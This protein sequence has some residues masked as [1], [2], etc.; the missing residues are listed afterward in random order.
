MRQAGRRAVIQI[1]K[2]LNKG[3]RP[4]LSLSGL[5]IQNFLRGPQE[6]RHFSPPPTFSISGGRRRR[7]FLK[8]KAKNVTVS[9]SVIFTR[10]RYG[11]V[12]PS[13]KRNEWRFFPFRLGKVFVFIT[14]QPA[15]T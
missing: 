11:L 15:M 14:F 5:L 2:S 7:G 10:R 13:M 1:R 12:F 4:Y 6:C 8:G 3:R 9:L